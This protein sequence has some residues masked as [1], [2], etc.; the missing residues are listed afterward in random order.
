MRIHNNQDMNKNYKYCVKIAVPLILFLALGVVRSYTDALQSLDAVTLSGWGIPDAVWEAIHLLAGLSLLFG[1]VLY[2]WG[3]K[4]NGAAFT[5]L[6]YGAGA[7]GLL[8]KTAFKLPRPPGAAQSTYGYP[9]GSMQNAVMGWGFLTQYA[10]KYTGIL[11]V[12]VSFLVGITRLTLGEHYITD[13]IGGV[14]LGIGCLYAAFYLSTVKMPEPLW[15]RWTLVLAVSAVLFIVGWNA[16]L[17]PERVGM[18]CGFL[19]G[20]SAMRSTWEPLSKTRGVIAIVLG[21]VIANIMRTLILHLSEGTPIIVV[22]T[23]AAGLWTALCP[24][25]FVKAKLL[26]YV[27]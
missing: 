10:V 24:Q 26:R 19:L 7:V 9:S 14:L 15:K 23:L 11:A 21:F 6:M 17:V 2:W 27:T 4:K 3:L 22:S 18:F 8:A 5:A 12:T 1:P 16:E 20:Y 25:L 13:V